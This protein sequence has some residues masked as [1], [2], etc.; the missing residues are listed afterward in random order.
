MSDAVAPVP[1]I[2]SRSTLFEKLPSDLRRDLDQAIINRDLPKYRDLH[3]RFDL[4]AYGVSFSAFFRYARRLR[5]QADMLHLAQSAL[6]N[7]SEITQALPTLFAYRLFDALN[8]ETAGS[9]QL[10]RLV[11]SW[12]VAANT[13]MA[14]QRHALALADATAASARA[15]QDARRR[16]AR[17]AALAAAMARVDPTSAPGEPELE[18]EE[19]TTDE[20]KGN[21]ADEVCDAVTRYSR[22]LRAD[23]ALGTQHSA[24]NTQHSALPASALT[25][26]L[27]ACQVSEEAATPV[28]PAPTQHSG[29]RTH[30]FPSSPPITGLPRPLSKRQ[31]RRE[32]ILWRRVKK[33]LPECQPGAPGFRAVRSPPALV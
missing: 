23:S 31:A 5:A 7:S 21:Q 20:T 22:L 32:R 25:A 9:R 30:H 27:A 3:A 18:T 28:P 2:P 12:R 8:G 29:L 11:D 17:R 19:Q 13:Q 1:E 6:P 15:E 16:D 4:A 10:H 24:L 14:L 26:A 33:G